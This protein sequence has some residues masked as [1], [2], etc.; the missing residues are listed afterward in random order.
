M[1]YGNISVKPGSVERFTPSGIELSDGSTI[2]ADVVIF[3]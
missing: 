3:A 2:E 1:K